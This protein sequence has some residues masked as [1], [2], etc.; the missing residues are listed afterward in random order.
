MALRS[1]SKKAIENIRKYIIENYDA[2]GYEQDSP[3]AAAKTF[4]EIAAVVLA[5]VARVKG[6]EVRRCYHFT[7]Q[8]AF[9]D[10]AAGLPGL[11]DTCYYY[12]REAADDLA[13]ILEQTPEDREKL[14][15]RYGERDAERF[16]S[17]LIFRELY[18]AA[19]EALR[20]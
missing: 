15:K 19:P 16:L 8:D 2:D 6:Y 14:A 7:W 20:A 11:L 17:N 5:D 18:K 12:N 3:E 13:K 10:W 4:E 1:N 9:A